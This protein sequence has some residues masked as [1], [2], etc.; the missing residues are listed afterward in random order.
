S[1]PAYAAEE[2]VYTQLRAVDI[3]TFN[4]FR[5]KITDEFFVFRN[6]YEINQSIDIAS[7]GRILDLAQKGYN[8]LPDSLSN[9]N[10]YNHLRTAIEVGIKYP[11]NDSNYTAILIA[12]ENY[13][14]KTNIQ[15]IKGTVEAYP[16]T[17]NAPLIVTLRGKV[18]DPTGTQIESYNYTWWI[19]EDGAKKILG[20][21]ISMTH[22][23]KEEGNFSVFLDVSSS[24]RNEQGYTDVLPFSS[25]ADVTIKEKVASVIIKVNSTT[26]RSDNELKFVPDEA[27]Y[28]LLFDAT[29][30]TPTS[31]AKFIQTSWDF[32]NGVTKDYSG[33][34]N[35]E[36]VVYAGEGD[37]TVTLKLKTNELKQVERK[38]IISIHDP[39]AT[40][41]SS[42][43][44]GFLGDKFT[45]SAQNSG[46]DKNLSYAWE[47]IDLN[48]DEVILRKAGTLFTYSFNEKGKYNVK[49]TVTLPSGETDVDSKIIYI[50]SRPPVAD[51][52]TSIP[53]PNK[54]NRIFFDASKSFDP[55][56]SDD[57]KL[58]Y[59]WTVDGNR[60]EL[61]EPN[62]NG[63]T[64]YFS[65][66]SIGE[67][68]VVLNVEDP[69]GISSQKKEKVSV[70][71][72]LS[73]DFFAFP[74]VAQR[75]NSIRFVGESPEA[76]FYEWDFGD[77]KT[78]G[79][80]DSDVTHRYIKS[81]IFKVE[82]KVRDKN[83]KE[84]TYTKNVYIGDSNAPYSFISIKDTTRNEVIYD[85]TACDGNGA[86]V[87][88]RVDSVTFSGKESVN[89][90]GKNDGLTYSWKLGRDSYKNSQE[91]TKKFDELGCFSIKLTVKS[92]DNGKTHS[93]L[94]NMDVRNLKP[95]LSTIDI[96]VVNEETDPVIVNISALG[97]EDRDG[98][99]QSYLWYYYTDIDSEPQ[100]FRAT[101]SSTTSFV[102]PKITGNYYFVVVMKD[103]NEQTISSED[104]TGSKY[105]I[106]LTGD[107]L[108][109][110]LISLSVDDSSIAIGDEVTFTSNVENILGQ[111]LSKKVKY[112]W[113]FDGDGFYD[114]ES[115]SNVESYK[116]T[117]SGKKHI[118]V[119]AKY[120]GFSNTKSI[121]VNV[122]NVLKPDFGYISIG[123]KFIFFDE[124]IGTSDSVRWDLGD[125]TIIN[126]KR[127][128]VHTY[129]DGKV[130]HYVNL[131]IAEGTKIKD[132]EKKVVKNVRNIITLIKGGLV[133]FSN[134]PIEED[135]I[136][137]E[138]E[139]RD[140]LLYIGES[141]PNIENYVIDYD[142]EYDSDLN[143]SNDDD[144]DNS[145]SNSYTS[146]EPIKVILNRSKIQKVRVF[147]KNISGEVVGSKDITIIKNY[148]E[149]EMVDIDS[150]IFEGVSES[151]KLKIE[152]LKEYVSALPKQHKLKAL[153]YVQK[154]QEEWGDNRE[155][156]NVILDF[157]GFIYD[158]EIS[159]TDEIINLLES[160]LVDNQKDQSEKAITFNA[161]KNLLPTT[162]VCTD[163]TE[164]TQALCYEEMVLKLEGIRDSENIE[165]SKVIGEEILEVVAVD[166]VMTNKEKTDFKAILK[167]LIYGGVE[168][169]PMEE[170]N[171][172][173]KETV[174][175][176]TSNFMGLLLGIFKWIFYIILGFIGIVT[177]YY[178][179]YLL[180]NKDKH[181]G[182]QDFIIEKTSGVKSIENRDNDTGMGVDILNDLNIEKDTKNKEDKSFD[183]KIEYKQEKIPEV[184]KQKEVQKVPEVKTE[185]IIKKESGKNEEVPDWLKGSF[186][187]DKVS[188]TKTEVKKEE[189]PKVKEEKSKVE[190][191][192]KKKQ[193]K[194]SDVK[195]DEKKEIITDKKIEEATK[196]EDNDI[197]DWLKG[198]F[199]EDK[200]SD[201]KKDGKVEA[202]KESNKKSDDNIPD[203]LKGSFT[204]DKKVKKETPKKETPKK[205]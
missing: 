186:T 3:G 21:N 56:F 98:V 133:L 130:S 61:E 9:K 196:I 167:T 50:N 90:T 69:D 162:I 24:H 75:L 8:Y 139:S 100:D 153:M 129:T 33:A 148:I 49:M 59:S 113:D 178:I 173:I 203:W 119:K 145:G 36:R 92:D 77:G 114:K 146:G 188:E 18:V 131:K 95:I 185:E 52:T 87:V 64:G 181:L 143:G 93:T 2:P 163:S 46:N 31:G 137:L 104:I 149:E 125:G 195:K 11:N 62:F 115:S 160:L 193:D 76:K 55:D 142:I 16:K 101:K 161:L 152:K 198:S 179:Y 147:I 19:Y 51:F 78:L 37:F 67:H 164:G 74:R 66:D 183:T 86:Y 107:N 41:I 127:Y 17:G 122:S 42:L 126:N 12:I 71:S 138:G 108:N 201:V 180:V 102:L 13:L 109:T 10:Y 132:V 172:I 89:I 106:T 68:S 118:K 124:S 190:I 20:D 202:K 47:I 204:E 1:S 48:K 34:P 117:S 79:G 4:E 154:L 99:I 192:Q 155:K 32:G 63:S 151:I 53:F 65:F 150:I 57:G 27:R 15:S 45:F 25:R 169:I 58:K 110:P 72:I 205:E 39:I 128:V 171:E 44:D 96:R 23:F 166:T 88:N 28:G 140:I 54:P 156:T 14:E 60:I 81:G 80:D 94:I 6:K 26:L 197:P 187:E 141:T 7:A 5:Y 158:I 199:T 134:F 189:K 70:K 200:A 191:S 176:G 194:I 111:D 43:D 85:P 30:S 91:F 170:K 97:A 184:I 157:E 159:N 136:I 120:K 123:S 84:N 40:I 182:F 174:S 105:F 116:Y 38:F 165:N 29:S 135:K 22:L 82:L 121:T 73:V 103:N 144:E 177:G 35:V 175:G 83:D 112:S 168:N